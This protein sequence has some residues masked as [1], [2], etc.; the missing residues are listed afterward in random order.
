MKIFLDTADQEII[1]KW[2]EAGII[3]GITTN[4]T[5]LSKEGGNP[6]K[7]INEI[8]SILPEG[9]ISVQVTEKSPEKVFKQAL[10]IAKIAP[11]I[12]VKIPCSKD[13]YPVIKEL[14]EKGIRIN[15][16]L[17]FTLSQALF[18]S[19]LGAYYISPFVGR[20]DDIDSDGIIRIPQIREMLDQYAYETQVLVASI[21][22]IRHLHDSILA[23]ADA[24]TLPV[25]ILEKAVS[26]PL[27]DKGIH[28]FD[29]DWAKLGI[30]QFP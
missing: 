15:I 20:L 27:T 12:I 4:P 10:E 3:N 28:L 22:S 26:H 18:M 16:T 14:A 11:N 5:H 21:R 24:A 19:K 2:A 29:E 8:C 9:D 6:K 13:Y 25:E 17:L 23:G 1:K 30:K 7:V